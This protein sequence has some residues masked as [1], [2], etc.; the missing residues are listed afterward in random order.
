MSSYCGGVEREYCDREWNADGSGCGCDSSSTLAWVGNA[1][2]PCPLLFPI[3]IGGRGKRWGLDCDEDK[4]DE[5]EKE[6][7]LA[8]PD[9][10]RFTTDDV[11][12][13]VSLL[14]AGEPGLYSA[15]LSPIRRCVVLLDWDRVWKEEGAKWLSYP[16]WLREKA[17]VRR[18]WTAARTLAGSF[19]EVS[20]TEAERGNA[21]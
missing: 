8:G 19:A 17:F 9:P 18:G 3:R 7:S 13:P 2:E 10:R 20:S 5:V 16:S 15:S 4:E 21:G 12:L 6:R 1:E 14:E 11:I